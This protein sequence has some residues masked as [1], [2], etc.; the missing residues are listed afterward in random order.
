MSRHED[1]LAKKYKE[2]CQ[3]MKQKPLLKVN[4]MTSTIAIPQTRKHSN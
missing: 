4:I 3:P 2:P 1:E